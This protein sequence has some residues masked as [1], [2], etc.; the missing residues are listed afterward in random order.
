MP[1]IRDGVY[2]PG[3]AGFDCAQLY[4]QLAFRFFDFYILC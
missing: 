4:G 3:D 1:L 2:E